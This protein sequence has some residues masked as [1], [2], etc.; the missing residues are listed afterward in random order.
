VEARADQNSKCERDEKICEDILA[1]EHAL[2]NLLAMPPVMYQK[3]RMKNYHQAQF[4]TSVQQMLSIFFER[5]T[6]CYL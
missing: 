4:I 2:K 3:W 5:V 1:K 6:G